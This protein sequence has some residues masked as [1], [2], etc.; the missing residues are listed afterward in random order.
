MQYDTYASSFGGLGM[1][2]ADV[3]RGEGPGDRYKRGRSEDEDE[4]IERRDEE[5]G[6]R[7][8]GDRDDEE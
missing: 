5:D 2:G 7:F 4:D 6:K 1:A 8:R 3:P